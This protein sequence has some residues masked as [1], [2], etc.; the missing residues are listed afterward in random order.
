MEKLRKEEERVVEIDKKVELQVAIKTGEF[1]DRMEANLGSVFTLVR[2]AKGKK[3]AVYISDQ[4]LSSEG[5]NNEGATKEIWRKTRRRAISEKRK[6]GPELVFEDSPPMLTPAKRTPRTNRQKGTG[7]TLHV[8]RSKAKVKT[9]LS[10]YVEKCKKSPRQPGMVA[11]VRFRNQAMEELQAIWKDE[12]VAY[13]GKVDAI[14]DIASRRTWKA[15]GE[16]EPIDLFGAIGREKE[17]STI[18]E[19][20]E[21][22]LYPNG[23][24]PDAAPTKVMKMVSTIGSFATTSTESYR[25]GYKR[26]GDMTNSDRPDISKYQGNP[27]GVQ[28]SCELGGCSTILA[29]KKTSLLAQ[30]VNDREDVVMIE[31]I[32]GEGACNIHS[33]GE[34]RCSRNRQRFQ[35]AIRDLR[36]S[37][38]TMANCA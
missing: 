23:G 8:T 34:A 15:F 10:P 6:R 18:V 24:L 27:A 4:G 19:G 33:N 13:N 11:K 30:T 28:E 35:F 38:V 31:T 2:K 14:F 16:V 37:F 36:S 1:F 25:P 3:H 12:G 17:E 9:K 29:W 7:G 32:A 20:E 22:E 26:Q 5:G 21:N